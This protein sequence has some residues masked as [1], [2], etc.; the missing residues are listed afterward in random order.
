[1]DSQAFAEVAV[2][3]RPPVANKG[4]VLINRPALQAG[5][6]YQWLERGTRC[7]LG[8]DRAIQQ[9][10]ARIT[11]DFLPVLRLDPHREL[12]RVEARARGHG[13]NLTVRRVEGHHRTPLISQ[14][15]FGHGLQIHIDG[16]L[17]VFPR[18]RIFLMQHLMFTSQI[19]DNRP[20]LA[21]NAHQ[22]VVVTLFDTGLADD[23]ALVVLREVG[24]IE[25]RF[26]DFARVADE[27]GQDTVLGVEALLGLDELHLG[28]R[29]RV[30]VRFHKSQLCGTQLFLNNDRL[31]FRTLAKATDAL[32]KVVVVQM[33]ALRDLMKMFFLEGFAGQDQAPGGVVVHN[34]PAIAVQ[35]L[36]ARGHQGE[37]FDPVPLSPFVVN[38]RA[39]DLQF[40]ET[41]HQYQKNPDGNVLESMHLRGRE[42]GVVTETS[43]VRRGEFVLGFEGRKTHR[44]CRTSISILQGLRTLLAA[45][46]AK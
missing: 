28:E 39:A 36:A 29:P 31:V 11:G 1:M 43:L 38:F 5:N 33:Q 42:A 24:N 45:G 37:G 15:Q 6:C 26:A 23:L 46:S 41:R 19:I 8:L 27:V 4:S 21:I 9:R 13:E 34:N 44:C 30:F 2:K 3:L 7:Q 22:P 18:Q 20:T 12:V 10:V 40:P 25:F 16:Q 32:E 17:Q 14:R 35:N